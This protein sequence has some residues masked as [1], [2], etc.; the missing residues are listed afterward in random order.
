MNIVAERHFKSWSLIPAIKYAVRNTFCFGTHQIEI[1]TRTQKV[2]RI[3]GE[4]KTELAKFSKA[5]VSHNSDMFWG[6]LEADRFSLT[7]KKKDFWSPMT[8]V[9]LIDLELKPS[10]T[11]YQNLY[12]CYDFANHL[13]FDELFSIKLSQK[14]DNHLRYCIEGEY[15]EGWQDL[16]EVA[17]AMILFI[18]PENS[19]SS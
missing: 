9:I 13:S 19:D 14:Q 3:I 18:N 1:N 5:K 7:F 15:S 11:S 2:Y 10:G 16:A 17:A 12:I 6:S 4:D 8:G